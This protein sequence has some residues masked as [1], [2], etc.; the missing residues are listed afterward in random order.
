MFG[1][2]VCQKKKVGQKGGRSGAKGAEVEKGGKSGAERGQR[3]QK[4]QRKLVL[5]QKY[6][7]G[8]ESINDIFHSVV[9]SV[10]NVTIYHSFQNREFVGQKC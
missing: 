8:S 10:L 5:M 6:H 4:N 2:K 9:K 3:R 1:E 7:M